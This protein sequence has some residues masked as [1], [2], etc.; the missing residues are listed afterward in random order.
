MVTLFNR[1]KQLK[2]F[3]SGNVDNQEEATP[4]GY[5]SWCVIDT[6]LNYK[7]NDNIVFNVRGCNLLD[8]HYKTFGSGISSTGR[9]LMFSIKLVL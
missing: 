1:N 2:D 6:Q 3:G 8:I 4:A 7:Y 9:S 5:P